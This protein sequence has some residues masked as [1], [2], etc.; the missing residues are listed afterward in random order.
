MEQPVEQRIK[1][2]LQK[3]RA[4]FAARYIDG[5]FVSQPEN[6]YYVSG[7]TGSDG[8]LIISADAAVLATDFRYT[9][10]A[11]RQAPGYEI[12]RISSDLASWFPDVVSRLNIEKLGFESG[13]MTYA[14]FQR[15]LDLVRDKKFA[16]RLVPV[17]N[18]IESV[19]AVKERDEIEVISRAA[20]IADRALAHVL[21]SLKTGTTEKSVA[22]DLEKFMREH[23]S[24][25]MPFDVI[26][27][28]GPN[29]AM[30]HHQPSDRPIQAGEP[31]VIDLGA[32]VEGYASDMTRTVCLGEPDAKYRQVYDIVLGAQLAAVAMI[33]PGMTG[34]QADL[35]A[36]TVIQEAGY[37]EA[38]G[39]SLGHGVG[40][41]THEMP[42]VGPRSTDIL[43]DGMVFTVEPGI[44][45][46]GWGGVRIEDTVVLDD[47]K[48]KAI[49]RSPK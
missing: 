23:G 26:V 44:Y 48:V 37:G 30:A 12:L 25:V 15:L 49:P 41:G 40:L 4:Q 3:L 29:A 20:A 28:S 13:F 16:V 1:N 7:F 2:R 10:Q 27:A 33:K 46:A 14:L 19:R 42:R 17:E 11:G 39:H 6:R 43:A 35:L 36:R 47:G 22:W 5:M 38:F 34:E 32:R 9:E 24:E 45:L 21:D 18:M 8:Y 31:V